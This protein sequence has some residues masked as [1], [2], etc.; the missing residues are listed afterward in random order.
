MGQTLVSLAVL[1]FCLQARGA[2]SVDPVP[3]FQWLNISALLKGSTRPPGLKDASMGYDENSRTIILF[4]G[5]ASSTVPQG[6]TYLLNLETLTWSVPSSPSTLQRTPPARSQSVFGCDNAASNRNGFIVIGGKGSDGTALSDVW[7]YDF[8]NQFWSEVNISPGG[9]SARWGSSGGIDTRIPAVS[10]PVLPGPNNTFWLWGGS[11]GKSSFSDLY[12]LNMSGTLSSNLPNDSVGTWERLPFGSLPGK[13]GQG[14]GV[15]SEKIVLSGGCNGTTA[16]EDSCA[17]QDTYVINAGGS[18]NPTSM[19]ALNCPAPRL[20]PTVV[21]NGNKFSTSFASQMLLL[22]GD[23]NST[24][25]NDDQGLEHGEVAILNTDTQSWTRILPSGDPGTTGT[26]SSSFPTPREGAVAL[27]YPLSLVGESRTTSSDIIV[28]GGKDSSGN[29]LSEV[30]ILRAYNAVVSP[31]APKWPG[32][33]NGKLQSG[34]NANGAGV[35]NTFISS[36]AASIVPSNPPTSSPSNS[37]STPGDASTPGDESNNNTASAS[38]LTTSLLHKLFAPLS[39]AL[40]LPS[41]LLFRLTSLSFNS[42]E[43][44]AL[45]HAWYLVSVLLGL[46]GYGLGIGGIATSFTT[47]S[48][49]TDTTRPPPLST[50]H[51]RAGIALFACLYGLTPLILVLSARHTNHT[52]VVE[53]QDSRK[54]ADSDVTEK[55]NL[56]GTHSPSPPTSTRRRTHSWGPSSWR[57][58]REDSLSIDS[59]SAEMGDS[60]SAPTTQRGFEVLNRPTR[61]RRASGSRL[62]VPL[63]RISQHSGSHSLADLDWLNR[64]RSLTAVGELDYSLNQAIAAPL[65]PSTPGTLLDPPVETSPSP[66]MPPPSS[67]LL[68]LFFHLSL[69]ALCVF[70]LVSLYFKAPRSTFGVFLAWTTA[71]YVILIVSGWRGR[72]DRSTLSLLSQRLRTEPPTSPQRPSVSETLPETDENV[73]AFPYIHRPAYRRTLLSDTRGGPSTDTEEEDDDRAEDEMRRR[74]ISIVTSYPKRALRITNPS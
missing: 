29:Y 30:W 27:M 60:H 67:L 38:P 70:C 73:V 37:T 66:I 7:E 71:F 57:K 18:T 3:P 2:L 54:R 10:D 24:L 12:R 64:R 25:W 40:L 32:F 34:V 63:T 1:S 26:P 65:P 74:D 46:A 59:G 43:N 8:N 16:S 48:S 51:G 50:A 44:R 4:G 11:N 22:L 23:F 47:I 68:R 6:Q 13:S 55:D 20:S 53:I 21:P 9:P 61:I 28:F 15:L 41:F 58:T 33:G 52:P 36:C 39:V 31:S 19:A 17:V 42:S 56:P 14:G 49:T 5:E 35:E 45:P 69:L 72:P 62:G